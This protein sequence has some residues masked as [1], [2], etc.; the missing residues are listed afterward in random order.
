MIQK[1]EDITY[2]FV[3]H[4]PNDRVEVQLGVFAMIGSKSGKIL[5]LQLTEIISGKLVRDI[6]F[7]ELDHAI[8]SLSELK[9]KT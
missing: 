9:E 5:G 2:K 7:I 3:G 4:I 1:I 8:K 6:S